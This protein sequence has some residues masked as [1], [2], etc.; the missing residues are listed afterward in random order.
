MF[1]IPCALLTA[2][3][4]MLIAKHIHIAGGNSQRLV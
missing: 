3:S 1:L 4:L 2:L